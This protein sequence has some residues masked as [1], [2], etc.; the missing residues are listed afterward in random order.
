MNYIC[1]YVVPTAN[2]YLNPT[3]VND[4]FV[5]NDQTNLLSIFFAAI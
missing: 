5:C 3:I 1:Q 2:N 4:T